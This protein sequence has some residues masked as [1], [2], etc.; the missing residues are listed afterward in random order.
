[1]KKVLVGRNTKLSLEEIKSRRNHFQVI[2]SG[3]HI[4]MRERSSR[5]QVVLFC[6][7]HEAV[8]GGRVKDRKKR[9]NCELK[10]SIFISS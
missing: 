10:E 4:Q 2:I 3:H 5:S 9:N 6:H 1:M 8:R 7:K